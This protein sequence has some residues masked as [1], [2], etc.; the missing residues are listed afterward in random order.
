LTTLTYDAVSSSQSLYR[1]DNGK[2]TEQ[3]VGKNA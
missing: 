3:T 1:L 2:M